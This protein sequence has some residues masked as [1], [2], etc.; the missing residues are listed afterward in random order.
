VSHPALPPALPWWAAVAA[1]GGL[2]GAWL[3]SKHLPAKAL[4]IM[5]AAVLLASGI[6]LAFA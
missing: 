5:L 1:L 2:L 3:G 4:R 6:R